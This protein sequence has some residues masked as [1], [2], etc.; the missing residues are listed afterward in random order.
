MFL[1]IQTDHLSFIRILLIGFK[2]GSYQVK[3]LLKYQILKS[4]HM[5]ITYDI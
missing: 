1:W 4:N 2:V 3:S 5:G